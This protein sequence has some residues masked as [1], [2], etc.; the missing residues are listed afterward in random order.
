M[1]NESK[2]R[3]LDAPE[4][5]HRL[6]ECISVLQMNNEEGLGI[7]MIPDNILKEAAIPKDIND[8]PIQESVEFN[9]RVMKN[10]FRELRDETTR[11][12]AMNKVENDVVGFVEQV[13][14]DNANESMM[15]V[16]ELLKSGMPNEEKMKLVQMVNDKIGQIELQKGV[17]EQTESSQ[18]QQ[19]L[20]ELARQEGV[21][22][23]LEDV[24]GK[25]FRD[26]EKLRLDTDRQLQRLQIMLVEDLERMEQQLED[27]T[28]NQS[29]VA[30]MIALGLA[31]NSPRA[32][33]LIQTIFERLD[34][35]KLK[36]DMAVQL[37]QQVTLTNQKL[38]RN[39]IEY[40]QVVDRVAKK[41]VL[42]EEK[43][44]ELLDTGYGMQQFQPLFVADQA[45][46][47]QQGRN[48]STETVAPTVESF[49]A[50]AKSIPAFSQEACVEE[51]VSI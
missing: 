29:Q 42:K 41:S 22:E 2:D 51:F 26:A 15:V 49:T 32:E 38:E 1:S 39:R 40:K 19:R 35:R 43:F 28:E 31:M 23:N 45:R 4:I 25:N 48:P 37:N 16:A 6:R 5:Y 36:K 8:R 11:E 17:D 27:S 7:A 3:L 50:L 18:V 44:D 46:G 24:Q 12:R 20:F 47:V 13:N 21:T 14:A 34:S 30:Q 10:T 9:Q 33:D